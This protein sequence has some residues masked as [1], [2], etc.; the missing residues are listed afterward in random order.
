MANINIAF[1]IQL[2]ALVFLFMQAFAV[3]PSPRVVWGWLGL[4]LWLLSLMIG[5]FTLHPTAGVH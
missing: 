3:R 1:I 5:V 4:A 2:F